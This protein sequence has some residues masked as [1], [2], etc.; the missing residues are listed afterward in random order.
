MTREGLAFASGLTVGSIARVELVQ[1]VPG[2]DTVRAI[3]KAL[4]V[5]LADLGGAVEAQER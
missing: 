5:S 4:N 3:A 1:S 2:W